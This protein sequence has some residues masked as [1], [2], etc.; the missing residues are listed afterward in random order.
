MGYTKHFNTKATKQTNQ[1]A[2]MTQLKNNAG[3]Y[4]FQISPQ[5]QLER[6][7]I[8]G[9]EGGTYYVDE[10][11][12]TIEN[13]KSIVELAQV[14]GVN[15]VNTIVEV[16]LGGKAPSNNP[17]IF[18]LA[19]CCTFGNEETKKA[20]YSAI[21][22]V[23]R[24]GTHIFDFCNE[25]QNLRGWSRGLRNG[26]ANY[27]TN[28]NVEKLAYQ[29]IK[30]RQRNGFT[31][32]DV[33]RLC[34]ASTTE[35]VRNDI[36]RYA[37]GKECE[38]LHPTIEA[39]ETVQ[40]TSDISEVIKLV[41]E[42]RLPWEALQ[43]EH[44]KH[45][46]VWSA[47]LPDMPI[48]ALVRNLGRMTSNGT[49]TSALDENVK[50]VVEKLTNITA[51][52]SSR[53][54]PMNLL[55]AHKT[56]TQ[57]RGMKGNLSWEPI[58]KVR[59]AIQD[60]FYLSFDNVEASGENYYLAL[61]VSGSMSWA[62]IGN[63]PLTPQEASAVMAMV[64]ARCETNCEIKGFTGALVDLNISPRD[65]FGEVM[66]KI[67]GLRFGR[68][69]C[70]QPMIDALNKK[71]FVDKFVIYTDNETWC[72]NIHPFQALEA[73][74]KAVNPNAKLIVCAMTPSQFSIANPS[75]SGML[76]IAGFSTSTPN[77]IS[78]F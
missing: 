9:S 42:Y 66:K 10:K 1:V 11:T 60:A 16:S 22:K 63:L 58:A 6:F 36:L 27:Y 33:L 62:S 67:S 52:K 24:I 26:V 54:H 19:I 50:C 8:L 37:V 3:G 39:F 23:C 59:D 78:N 13:A 5:A 53:I 74:R 75:D 15:T 30:Y 34:H 77:V 40:K 7:L 32:R 35:T 38:T 49:L 72:G 55:V 64:T 71:L 25:I 4:V 20:S 61:D 12:L 28:K 69:D 70:A 2:G 56:Y 18:A 29:V 51:V 45:N 73:Y 47:L 46:S 65:S 48:T 68:T 76:D 31:H 44:L 43:T 17:A 21:G 14:D 57:G 41:K